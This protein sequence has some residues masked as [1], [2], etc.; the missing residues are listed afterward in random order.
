MKEI[1]L[2]KGYKCFVDD[3]VYPLLSCYNWSSQDY[4]GYIHAKR[5]VKVNGLKVDIYMFRQ[6]LGVPGIFR[7]QWNSKNR[8]DY[9]RLNMSI[10]D[11]LGNIYQWWHFTGVSRYKGIVW[12]RYFG[13]WRVEYHRLV[14]GYYATEIDACRAWNVQMVKMFPR[15]R[16]RKHKISIMRKYFLLKE[17]NV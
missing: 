16:Y 2:T 4:N 5:T 3:E 9:R 10:K 1:L 8:L 13:L 7:V 6:I 12:D 11:R 15:S 14:I 17:G